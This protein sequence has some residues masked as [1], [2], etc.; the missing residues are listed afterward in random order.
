MRHAEGEAAVR[1]WDIRGLRVSRGR[2]PFGWFG[3]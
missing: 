1:G 3:G 2:E